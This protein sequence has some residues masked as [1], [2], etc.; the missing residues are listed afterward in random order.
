MEDVDLL[1]KDTAVTRQSEKYGVRKWGLQPAGFNQMVERIMKYEFRGVGR[2]RLALF[3]GMEEFS[4]C[5][6]LFSV[7]HWR[8]L[9]WM[10]M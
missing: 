6:A 8:C 4:F 3:K 5:L 10:N 9:S 7:G 2:S 1:G